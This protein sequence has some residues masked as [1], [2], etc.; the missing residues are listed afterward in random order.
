MRVRDAL[1]YAASSAARLPLFCQRICYAM[2]LIRRLPGATRFAAR[3]L[4]YAVTYRR[5]REMMFT[6]LC[7][8]DSAIQILRCCRDNIADI[9]Y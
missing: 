3:L 6:T 1:S 7:A 8:R 5:Q 4:R 9:A 2:L